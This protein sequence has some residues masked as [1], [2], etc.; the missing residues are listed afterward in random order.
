MSTCTHTRTQYQCGLEKEKKRNAYKRQK[1]TEN[2]LVRSEA[3]RD[4]PTNV[5]TRIA[6]RVSTGFT[7]GGDS[8][9][10]ESH[11]NSE[12]VLLIAPECDELRKLNK[13]DGSEIGR[14]RF[15]K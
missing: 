13:T 12:R 5:R 10:S 9:S 7:R 1:E 2:G 8:E 4:T 11:S 3:D 6:A 15:P 14:A